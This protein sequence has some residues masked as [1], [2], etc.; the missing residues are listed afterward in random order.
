MD[1]LLLRQHLE[2]EEHH[3]WFVGRRRIL[4]DVL[5]RNLAPPERQLEILDAGC[6]GG[7][8]MES[9]ACYGRVQGLDISAEAVKHNREQ[10]REVILGS[11]EQ[12]PL[13]DNSF[14]LALALDVIAHVP[15]DLRALEELFRTL[16][17][18]GSL[19]VTV[20][21]LRMLWSAHDVANGHYRRYTLGELHKRVEAAGFE[22]VSATYF[23]TLLFPVILALRVLG[24]LHLKSS[25]SDVAEIPRL[26]NFLLTKIF[27]LEASFVGRVRLPFGV[28]GLCFAYKP[29]RTN[30]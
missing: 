29:E 14:D 9:L 4:L 21:A 8:M 27:S 22:I 28:S 7:A 2:F 25:A 11:I 17:P 15:D 30:I 5:K 26:L 23:N 19:L 18:G 20:P 12:I 6:G 3:W 1:P 13:P 24:R 10:G 16:R